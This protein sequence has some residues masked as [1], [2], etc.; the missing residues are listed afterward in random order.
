[1]MVILQS[2]VKIFFKSVASFL[3][4][5]NWMN[6]IFALSLFSISLD[7]PLGEKVESTTLNLQLNYDFIIK[8]NF[9]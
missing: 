3:S 2:N 1:M 8:L 6:I 4:H 9:I 5:N 7:E